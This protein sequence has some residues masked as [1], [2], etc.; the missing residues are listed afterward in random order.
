MTTMATPTPNP[1]DSTGYHRLLAPGRWRNQLRQIIKFNEAQAVLGWGIIMILVALI[2]TIYLV[3]ASTI[4]ETGRRVQILQ[5][6]LADL[7]RGNAQLERN[8]AEAQSLE[9]LQTSARQLGFVRADPE[10]IEYIIV[11][12]YPPPAPPPTA[13]PTATLVPLTSFSE[14]AWITVQHTF[15]NLT[16]GEANER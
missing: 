10:E 13:V 9:R 4:A 6:E 3:Q 7:K 14:A 1:Q 11:P 15:T 2:G 8:I 12:D 16:T 5:I